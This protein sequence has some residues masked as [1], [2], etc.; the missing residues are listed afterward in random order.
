M[1]V[2]ARVGV[3]RRWP[4]ECPQSAVF[5][6]HSAALLPHAY[7]QCACGATSRRHRRHDALTK[8]IGDTAASNLRAHATMERHLS[9]KLTYSR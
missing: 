8:L 7:H 5:P 6:P 3:A 4:R 2:R 9:R 1:R